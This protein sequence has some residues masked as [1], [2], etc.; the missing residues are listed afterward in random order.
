MCLGPS[1]WILANPNTGNGSETRFEMLHSWTR[2]WSWIDSV[3]KHC[4]LCRQ[5]SRFHRDFIACLSKQHLVHV[6]VVLSSVAS[7]LLQFE[8]H[9]DRQTKAQIQT[10]SG[11]KGANDAQIMDLFRMATKWPQ[12]ILLEKI[13]CVYFPHFP[14]I[15]TYDDSIKKQV[16]PWWNCL[17]AHVFKDPDSGE[18]LFSIIVNV[19]HFGFTRKL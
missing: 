2:L 15:I 3:A 5:K 11:Q 19:F 14:R 6:W 10:T 17:T 4:Q 8:S 18:F 16:H 13:S 9:C 1:G 12:R 7:K